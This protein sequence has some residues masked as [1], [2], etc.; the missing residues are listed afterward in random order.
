MNGQNFLQLILP[1]A[2]R[3]DVFELL[4]DDLGHQGRDRTMSLIKQRLAIDA[5]FC[6]NSDSLNSTS[7]TEYIR[8]LR[9]CLNFAY[10]KAREVS[11]KAGS[12]H[13]RNYERTRSS[14]LR[15]WDQVL[16][17]NAGIRGRC[18]LADQ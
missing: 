6:L 17:R 12:K 9:D 7:Q 14:G 3:E 11:N 8:K 18:K 5:F 16:V 4:H 15:I 1:P 10:K 2:F 13:K